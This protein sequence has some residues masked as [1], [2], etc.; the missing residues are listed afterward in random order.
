MCSSTSSTVTS[1]RWTRSLTPAGT[2]NITASHRHRKEGG[3]R[4][5]G[6]GIEICGGAGG[7]VGVDRERGQRA[8]EG[9][10][11]RLVGADAAEPGGLRPEVLA[12]AGQ[13]DGLPHGAGPLFETAD[14]LGR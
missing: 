14:R 6:A 12:L 7:D 3:D 2:V 4:S 9:G 10:A 13:L 5:V 11:V 8:A 1:K